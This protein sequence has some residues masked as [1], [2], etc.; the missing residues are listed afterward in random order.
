VR[1]G[2]VRHSIVLL[3]GLSHILVYCKILSIAHGI[4]LYGIAHN[5]IARYGT[6]QFGT[7]R[8]SS[9]AGE[10][11]LTRSTAMEPTRTAAISTCFDFPGL[12]IIMPSLLKLDIPIGTMREKERVREREV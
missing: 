4:A 3:I 1:H 7:M 10:I 2:K 12:R 8:Y 6:L 9:P 5:G 11:K